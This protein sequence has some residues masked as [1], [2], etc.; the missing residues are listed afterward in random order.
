MDLTSSAT[1]TYQADVRPCMA[2]PR[3]FFDL[4]KGKSL[5]EL[6]SLAE[7]RAVENFDPELG[8]KNSD[9]LRPCRANG[10][11]PE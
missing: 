9:Q 10:G 4:V 5:D 1:G 6:A 7:V 2:P 8:F 3:R 11:R